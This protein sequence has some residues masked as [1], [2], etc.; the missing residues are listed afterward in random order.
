MCS[1]ECC[2]HLVAS[3]FTLKGA[4]EIW[5]CCHCGRERNVIHKA[6]V[7]GFLDGK[8]HGPYATYEVVLSAAVV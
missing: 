7:T 6:E 1:Q 8:K 5:K 2:D 4:K 3:L